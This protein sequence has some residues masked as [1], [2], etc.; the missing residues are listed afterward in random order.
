MTTYTILDSSSGE[1][2]ATGCSAYE[3]MV[4]ILTDD[5]HEWEI[6][7][8]ADGEGYRLWTTT[9]S[10]NSTAYSGLTQSVVYSLQADEAAATQEIAGKVINAA[11]PRKPEAITDERY[12]EMMAELAAEQE[13]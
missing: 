10:R 9:Y 11:W 5:G 13:G 4:E 6:R 3:A 12:A 2:I 7:P 8:E 1:P